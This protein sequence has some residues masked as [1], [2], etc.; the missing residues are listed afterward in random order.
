[1]SLGD[2]EARAAIARARVALVATRS[3]RGA[4]FVTPLWF[5]VRDGHLLCTTSAASVTVRNLDVDGAA[6]VLLYDGVDESA[7]R[8]LRL[9]GRATARRGPLPFGVIARMAAKYYASPAGLAVE[10]AHARLW[11]L[12]MRYYAQ[13]EAALLDFV[14]ADAAFVPRPR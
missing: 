12:R 13:G 1:M 7:P 6:S 8:L 2:P 5:V 4:P 14:P 3:P 11:P 10:L 9:R